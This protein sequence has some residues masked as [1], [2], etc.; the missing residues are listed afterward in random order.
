MGD[1]VWG[2]KSCGQQRGGRL[3]TLAVTKLIK[4]LAYCEEGEGWRMGSSSLQE[5]PRKLQSVHAHSGKFSTEAYKPASDR[6][7]YPSPSSLCWSP[8]FVSSVSFRKRKSNSRN[9][10]AASITVPCVSGDEFLMCAED[11]KKE[12][13]M[14]RH[15]INSARNRWLCFQHT[16]KQQCCLLRASVF[17]TLVYSTMKVEAVV[18]FW[19]AAAAAAL[20]LRSDTRVRR[21][22]DLMT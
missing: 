20:L 10:S 6:L 18:H 2:E 21:W 17:Y 12:D 8:S 19:P 14:H 15:T 5:A 7:F 13:T 9:P 1:S 11:V 22:N 16:D 3:P 4:L